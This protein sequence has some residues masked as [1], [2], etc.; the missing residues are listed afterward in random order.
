MAAQPKFRAAAACAVAGP[1]AWTVACGTFLFTTDFGEISGRNEFL[2]VLGRPAVPLT[3]FGI[4]GLLGGL[5]GGGRWRA[6][7]SLAAGLVVGALSIAALAVAPSPL[8]ATAFPVAAG[9]IMGVGYSLGARSGRK[10]SK[11]AFAGLFAGLAT[12]L[13]VFVIFGLV[14]GVF[15]ARSLGI[16]L[17][18]LLVSY[19]ATMVF[20]VFYSTPG[21]TARGPEGR[22]NGPGRRSGGGGAV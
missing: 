1:V 20:F 13:L 5:I 4:L 12:T 8:L 10:I 6:L 3:L 18:G 11:G 14:P 21:G 17:G 19:I 22:R 15:F 2:A 7:S 16:Y 9:P